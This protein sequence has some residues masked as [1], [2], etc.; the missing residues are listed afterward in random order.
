MGKFVRD[1]WATEVGQG[2][3]VQKALDTEYLHAGLSSSTG[4][5]YREFLVS[6]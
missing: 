4:N 2:N 1:C 3:R 5:E 6:A